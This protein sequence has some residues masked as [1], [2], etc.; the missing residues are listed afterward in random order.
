MLEEF[1]DI[2]EKRLMTKRD[3]KNSSFLF[4]FFSLSLELT[5]IYYIILLYLNKR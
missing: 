3:D 1:L 4:R 2:T 5:R